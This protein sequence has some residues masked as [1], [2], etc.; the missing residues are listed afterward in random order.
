MV[1]YPKLRPVEAFPTEADGRKVLC[2]RDPTHYAEAVLF[3]PPAAVEILRHFDGEHSVLDIQAAYVR[4]HGQLLFREEVEELIATLDQHY[5]LEGDRFTRHQERLEAQFRQAATRPAFLA[6]RSYPQEGS[7]LGQML[8]QMLQHPQGPVSKS[9]PVK[10]P[11]HAL[12]AP[13]IDFMRG[14]VG[15]AWGYG[16]LDQRTDAELF[17]I[18]GTA[19]GGTNRP[20]APCA[21]DFE[22]PLGPV[23]T[24]RALVEELKRRCPGLLAVDDIAHR[25]EHSIEF[26]VILLQHLL[27]AK[28]PFRILPILCG[29]L[30]EWVLAGQVPSDDPE[31]QRVLEA[32][33]ELLDAQDTPV[34]LVAGADLAHVGPR[35]GDA[36]P[37]TPDLLR[38][39]E[40]QDRRM[41]APVTAGDPEGFFRF[42]SREKDRRRVCGL[43]PVYTLLHLMRGRTA[44]LLHYGQ[45]PDP[46]G[47]VTFCSMAFPA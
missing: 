47:V 28:R 43:P 9:D 30:Q 11:I 14:G 23:R 29:S 12:I 15:Y 35:F 40:E 7:E 3:V 46:Q 13:H 21:K 1:E 8:E 39:I 26:Q 33:R 4:C 25:A 38:W 19:H 41:L 37:I 10:D 2:L 18:F 45:A 6:G 20:F 27:G 42:V 36:G 16:G 24:D 22:T 34:C 5:F 44:E 31:V 32:L 17:V